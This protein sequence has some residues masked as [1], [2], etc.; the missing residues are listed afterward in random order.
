MNTGHI[1]SIIGM[2]I[3]VAGLTVVLSNK[4]TASDIKA[5]GDSFA[6]SLKAAMGR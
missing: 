4:N 3:I 6:G 1:T 5:F 2:I